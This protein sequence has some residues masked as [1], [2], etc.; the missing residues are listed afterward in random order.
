MSFL[1]D[2]EQRA[3]TLPEPHGL[4][5]IGLA[6]GQGPN[7]LEV[8]IASSPTKPTSASL[9]AAW[10]GRLA[11]RATP[12][13]LVAL[14][15]G[16]AAVC[17]PASDSPAVFVDKEPGRIERLCAAALAEPDRHAAIRFLNSAIPELESKTSGIRNEGL[18]ASHESGLTRHLVFVQGVNQLLV[19]NQGL[20]LQVL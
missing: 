11:G 8:A 2:I 13:L 19:Q 12:L 4:Q 9:R 20:A 17:G 18:F 16:K 5:P 1:P 15:D 14:Y 10:K 6:L 7:A 3:L